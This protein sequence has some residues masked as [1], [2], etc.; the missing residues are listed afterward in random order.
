MPATILVVDDDEPVRILLTRILGSAGYEVLDAA[1]SSGALTLL[2]RTPVALVIS[3]VV[4]P[5]G[6]GIDLRR[7]IAAS[8]PDLPV[9]LV[10]GFSSEGP[11]E[12]AATAA[13]TEFL[14][15]PFAARDLLDLVAEVLARGEDGPSA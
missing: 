12:F 13:K 14:Q 7:A 11:A 5:G 1:R 10:S 9:I 6:S 2:E 3:D 15:K 8:Y 4:M